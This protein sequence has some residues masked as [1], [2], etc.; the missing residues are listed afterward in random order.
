MYLMSRKIKCLGVKMVLSGEGSDEM[1]GGYLYVMHQHSA[2]QKLRATKLRGAQGEAV[3]CSRVVPL[4]V[5]CCSARQLF[6]QVPLCRRAT[7][8]M[9]AQTQGA[10]QVRS[11]LPH[12]RSRDSLCSSLSP[13]LPWLF[14]SDTTP[15]LLCELCAGSIACARTN[16]QPP[17]VSKLA[18]LS[19]TKSSWIGP[20]ATST[21]R[22]SSVELSLNR[23]DALRSG[24]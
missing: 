5:L 10:L 15:L 7:E 2:R 19:W 6:P 22:T 13:S 20:W 24:L 18:Y 17:G 14:L 11:T 23:R 16:P 9:C 12:S 1:F 8:G 4:A 21:P 3:L